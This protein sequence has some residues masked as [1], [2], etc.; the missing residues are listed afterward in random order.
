MD[1]MFCLVFGGLNFKHWNG[2]ILWHLI[3]LKVFAC[4]ESFA[5]IRILFVIMDFASLWCGARLALT[6][7]PRNHCALVCREPFKTLAHGARAVV[8][9]SLYS[10]F[11]LSKVGKSNI[12]EQ[13]WLHLTS[14]L[15][16]RSD[17]RPLQLSYVFQY[18]LLPLQKEIPK[19]LVHG[20]M[21]RVNKIRFPWRGS[22]KGIPLY[23]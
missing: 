16:N 1:D 11:F 2:Y 4:V 20:E 15:A 6:K 13:P 8:C 10:S 3:V 18:D 23:P 5:F 12:A 22:C 14:A 17:L 21:Y 19:S 7:A 9:I